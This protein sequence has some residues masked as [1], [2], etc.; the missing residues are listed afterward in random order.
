MFSGFG[1]AAGT[2]FDTISSGKHHIHHPDA[3]NLSVAAF[4]RF[5]DAFDCRHIR[6]VSCE[7]FIFQRHS[8]AG[9]DQ[10]DAHLFAVAAL[11]SRVA[12]LCQREVSSAFEECACHIVQQQVVFLFNSL[13]GS[14]QRAM[15]RIRELTSHGT[16]LRPAGIAL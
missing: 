11:V 8:A 16:C 9:N 15:I 6:R 13:E 3:I 12:A 7:D 10:P 14:I 4:Y 1:N 2:D 5:D